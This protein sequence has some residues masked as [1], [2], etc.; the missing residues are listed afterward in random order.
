MFYGIKLQYKTTNAWDD[1]VI[2]LQQ[3]AKFLHI[4]HLCVCVCCECVCL[5]RYIWV[6]CNTKNSS[7]IKCWYRCASRAIPIIYFIRILFGILF[8]RRQYYRFKRQTH[9]NL[10]LLCTSFSICRCA[11]FLLLEFP[12]SIWNKFAND[13]RWETEI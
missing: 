2:I 13:W 7:A 9:P 8:Y 5:N 11:L 6:T 4:V 10:R 1:C 12:I 3:I